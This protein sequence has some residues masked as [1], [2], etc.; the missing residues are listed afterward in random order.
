LGGPTAVAPISSRSRRP[1]ARLLLREQAADPGIA[2]PA[3]IGRA[4]PDL[5]LDDRG[6]GP[7]RANAVDGEP[8]S[9]E[10]AAAY[11]SAATRDNPINPNLDE[12][13]C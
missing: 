12:M 4:R 6:L 13:P 2:V 7:A 5:R 9:R 3:E 11:S 10:P 1:Q 8:L